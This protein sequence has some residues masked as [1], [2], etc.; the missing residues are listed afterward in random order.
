[1][2]GLFPYYYALLAL[3]VIMG[4][5]AGPYHPSATS[6]L[7]DFFGKEQR[8]KAIALHMV[9]GSIGFAISPI[10]GGILA[11]WFGWRFAFIIL[12]IPVMIASLLVF[13]KFGKETSARKNQPPHEKTTTRDMSEDGATQR[14]GIVQALRPIILVTSL[15]VSIQLVAGCAMAFIPVYLVDRHGIVPAVSA[16]LLG[17]VR[18][19]G[20]AGS[21]FGGWLSDRWNRENAIYLSLF[22]I[23]PILY[24]ITRLPFSFFYMAVFFLFG[25]FVYMLQATIQPLI[26]DNSPPE[27]RSTIF[28]IYFG[29]SMEGISLLQPVAGHFM[30]ILGIADVFHI[31][32]LVSVALSIVALGLGLVQR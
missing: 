21:L 32:A 15:A 1:M 24:V 27:L 23:G 22:M 10:L 8:G 31:I 7:S 20:I 28:G 6:M 2:V 30:D 5:F 18:T 19:G 17:V 16:M 11:T 4:L 3:M 26:M 13:K 29:L 9:G 14:K 12:G 25:L